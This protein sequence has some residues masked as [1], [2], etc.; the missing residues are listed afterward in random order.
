MPFSLFESARHIVL[1]AHKES[2]ADSL[3]SACAF[4]S[5]LLRDHKK[6]TLFSASPVSTDLGFLPWYDKV[7]DRFPA[8]ADC[9]VCF[10]CGSFERLGIETSLPVV[11]FDH[12]KSNGRFGTVNIVDTEA[13]STTQI[14]YDFFVANGIKINAKMALSL[15]AGLLDDSRCFSSPECSAKTFAMAQNLLVAGADHAMCVEWLYHRRS[16]AS[17]RARGALFKQMKLLLDGRLA[18]FQVGRS[19]LEETGATMTECKAVLDEALRMKTV[20]AAL[21]EFEYPGGGIKLSLRTDGTVDA[22]KVMESFGGGGHRNR[23]GARIRDTGFEGPLEEL[24]MNI[25]KEL[26]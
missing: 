15:Y 24:M 10:D 14:V 4:Y 5:Y 21:M 20:R 11:N 1:I 9:V 13:I 23:S 18:V 2:D 16:L 22:A 7:T 26:E 25:L 12:H 3:G 19:L 6:M 8:D 17:M